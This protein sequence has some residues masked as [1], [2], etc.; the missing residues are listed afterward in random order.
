MGT[1]KRGIGWVAVVGLL[2]SIA[3]DV[4]SY[5]GWTPVLC[6]PDNKFAVFAN[7]GTLSIEWAGDGR[8]H[9]LA[10]MGH[11]VWRIGVD[12]N[13]WPFVAFSHNGRHIG[14]GLFELIFAL[15]S[16]AFLFGPLWTRRLRRREGRCPHCD[17]R[18]LEIA[19][20]ICPECGAAI[21][22][23]T[24][25]NSDAVRPSRWSFRVRRTVFPYL[26]AF[27]AWILL[28]IAIGAIA[29]SRIDG[30]YTLEA[31]PGVFMVASGER[32]RLR[33]STGI[34]EFVLGDTTSSFC[35]WDATWLP[36]VGSSAKSSGTVSPVVPKFT[37]GPATME[38]S[39]GDA[40]H[41]WIYLPNGVKR[42]VEPTGGEDSRVPGKVPSGS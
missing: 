32:V 23:G 14:I 5:Y 38:W 12:S 33:A 28:Q 19:S 6:A 16:V 25:R 41:S 22:E 42:I 17:Y 40:T 10:S 26:I 37:V 20:N 3:A 11:P 7:F 30:F 8:I 34:I 13:A 9:N 27:G 1:I 18:V 35:K 39:E 31:R 36:D 2:L 29:P 21:P 4:G 15:G 24:N